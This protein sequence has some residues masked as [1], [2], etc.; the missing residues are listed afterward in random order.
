MFKKLLI[1]TA[2]L[3]LALPV[4]AAQAKTIEIDSLDNLRF[5]EE[6]ITVQPGETVTI[7][8]VNNSKIPAIAMSHNWVLLK[9]GID[10]HAFDKAALKAGKDNDYLPKGM[11]DQ[12]IAH[13]GLVGGGE[14]DTVTFTAPKTPGE[15]EYICTFPGHFAAGMKGKLVV[16]AQ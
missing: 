6:V 16:K 10:V 7:K 9:A 2:L 13:T 15:Y 12:I 11:D 3:V 8:L 14:S 5:S 1:A 4:V